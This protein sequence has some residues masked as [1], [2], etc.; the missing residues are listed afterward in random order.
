M[1]GFA[2]NGLTYAFGDNMSVVKNT[3]APESVLR[4][5]CN[6]ICYHTVREAVA[7]T[8]LIIA[9]IPR[10][11]NPSDLLTKAVP[12]GH[13]RETL[14]KAILYDIHGDAIKPLEKSKGTSQQLTLPS[15]S[16][17]ERAWFSR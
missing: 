2:I 7:T 17:G 12:G 6:S 15:T 1:M 16:M 8:E 14:V 5:K 10:V 13:R 9:H 3:S 11:S 4:K